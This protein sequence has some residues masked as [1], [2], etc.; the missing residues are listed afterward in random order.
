MMKS[1]VENMSLTVKLE[2]IKGYVTPGNRVARVIF[3]GGLDFMTSYKII[4]VDFK[5]YAIRIITLWV[6]S[7]SIF[8]V[9][10]VFY[11]FIIIM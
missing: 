8:I 1:K 6:A 11:L 7:Q 2:I 5:L 9:K 4:N 3:R 10:E